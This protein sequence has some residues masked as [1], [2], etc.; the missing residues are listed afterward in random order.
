MRDVRTGSCLWRG[1][2]IL[3]RLLLTSGCSAVWLFSA[4]PRPPAEAE[5][6]VAR[7]DTEARDG[8]GREAQYLLSVRRIRVHVLPTDS[9]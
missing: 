5:R 9:V 7:A 3:L 4:A 2:L 1:F 6:L 8:Q